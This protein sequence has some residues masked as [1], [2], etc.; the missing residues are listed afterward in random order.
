MSGAALANDLDEAL[1]SESFFA[2]PYATYAR[3]RGE[4]PVHWCEPWGQ[5][6]IT[7][8]ADVLAAVGP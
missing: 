3:L 4:D 7:S 1:N 5:W 2:D 6:V 8:F